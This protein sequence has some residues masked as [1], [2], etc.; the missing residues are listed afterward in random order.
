MTDREPDVR[1]IDVTYE[2][3][4]PQRLTVETRRWE[5]NHSYGQ[6]YYFNME[7]S[8]AV[9]SGVES[10]D[11]ERYNV[12]ENRRTRAAAADAVADLPFVQAVS[13]FDKEIGVDL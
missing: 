5:K 4:E 8:T 10:N 9:L 1:P 2:Y 13:M 3:S 12:T 7:G 6:T 11:G